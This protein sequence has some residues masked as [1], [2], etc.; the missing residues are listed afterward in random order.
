[1]PAMSSPAVIDRTTAEDTASVPPLAIVPLSLIALALLGLLLACLTRY[2][3]FR[4]E[5]Y[6]LACADRPAAG[7]VD[8]PPLSIWVLGAWRALFGESVAA[9]R[10]LPALLG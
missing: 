8:Q 9:L 4:D 2:G 7:Y 5:F 6:Y 1:M 10:V 3:W